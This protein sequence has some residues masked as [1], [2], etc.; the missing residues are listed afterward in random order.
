MKAILLLSFALGLSCALTSYAHAGGDYSTLGAGCTV[1]P[2]S[3]P[4]SYANGTTTFRGSFTGYIA[5]WCPI[6]YVLDTPTTLELQYAENAVGNNGW[7]EADLCRQNVNNGYYDCT[8]LA[9]STVSDGQVHYTSTTLLYPYDPYTYAYFIRVVLKRT[10]A[11]ESVSF[12]GASI[13]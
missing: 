9:Y 1:D 11:T 13:Y 7:V 6:T 12:F 3:V 5:L 8:D 2:V 4:H 10:L